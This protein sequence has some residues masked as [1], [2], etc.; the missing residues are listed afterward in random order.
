MP[1]GS[2]SAV[3]SS[4]NVHSAQAENVSVQ[5]VCKT[6]TESKVSI[7]NTKKIKDLMARLGKFNI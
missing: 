6:N 5:S 7:E 1:S 2:A 3:T 4:S